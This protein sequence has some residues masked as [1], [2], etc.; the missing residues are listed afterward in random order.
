VNAKYVHTNLVAYD[1]QRLAQFYEGLFG[2]V[3][4]LPQRDLAGEWLDRLTGL[5]GA[6]IRGLHLRLPGYGENGPTLEIFSYEPELERIA[7]ATNRPGYGHI[8]F[9]VDDVAKART[10]VLAADGSDHGELVQT[11]IGDRTLT[12]VYVRDPENNII[13]L[14]HWSEE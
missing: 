10:A 12:V 3:P 7:A 2:C 5:S 8:A 13:E 4:V 6:R 14:Q 1:Y 11:K 9:L